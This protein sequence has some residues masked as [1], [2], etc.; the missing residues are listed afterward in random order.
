MAPSIHKTVCLHD[1]PDTRRILT[2]DAGGRDIDLHDCGTRGE[3]RVGVG[4]AVETR[5]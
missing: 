1:S 4:R 3:R 2:T 5:P